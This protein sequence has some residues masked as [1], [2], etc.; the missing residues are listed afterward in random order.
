MGE[1]WGVCHLVQMGYPTFGTVICI[2]NYILSYL[3]KIK[4]KQDS[5]SSPLA[6]ISP[7]GQRHLRYLESRSE[8]PGVPGIQKG[9]VGLC[10]Y[11]GHSI[12]TSLEDTG[13]EYG[14]DV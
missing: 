2:L 4:D 12:V 9:S 5:P 7:K 10:H 1:R 3:L 14:Q 8:M 13:H 6:L 11:R